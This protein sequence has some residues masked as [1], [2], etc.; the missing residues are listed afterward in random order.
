M[1]A[2]VLISLQL[3]KANC[4]FLVSK[5]DISTKSERKQVSK[6]VWFNNDSFYYFYDK[7]DKITV[8]NNEWL[9]IYFSEAL[10]VLLLKSVLLDSYYKGMFYIF[11]NG[12]FRYFVCLS[13]LQLFIFHTNK[14]KWGNFELQIC[15][16][17]YA[18]SR[19]GLRL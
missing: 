16:N 5:H 15:T 12:I 3:K 19:T 10:Q 18:R 1:I 7:E 4:Q 8:N 17:I 9:N 13:S 2:Q 14:L 11:M 6:L